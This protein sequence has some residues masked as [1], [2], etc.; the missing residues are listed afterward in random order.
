MKIWNNILSLFLV[1]LWLAACTSDDA[2]EVAPSAEDT[3]EVM[4]VIDA[5]APETRATV[6]YDKEI[7]TIRIY[8]YLH[9]TA[10][11]AVSPIGYYYQEVE[12][13]GPY[14]CTMDLP[15]V[16]T[17]VVDFLVTLNDG[18]MSGKDTSV[19]LNENTTRNEV[20]NYMFTANTFKTDADGYFACP[21]SN[22]LEEGKTENNVDENNRSFTIRKTTAPQLIDIVCTR[23]MA[24]LRLQFAKIGEDEAVINSATLRYGARYTWLMREM[25]ITDDAK[26]TYD[27]PRNLEDKFLTSNVVINKVVQ[28][29]G[30]KDEQDYQNIVETYM[31]ENLYGA[32]DAD[33]EPTV[34]NSDRIYRLDISYTTN[35]TQHTKKVYLPPVKRN[36]TINVRGT[37]VSNS[38]QIQLTAEPWTVDANEID[39][40]TDWNSEL[41]KGTSYKEIPDDPDTADKD[42]RAVAVATSSDGKARGATFQFRVSSPEGGTWTAHLSSTV[43]F[44]LEGTTSGVGAENPDWA[45]FTIVPIGNYNPEITQEVKLFI[46][47]ASPFGGTMEDEGMQII[48]PKDDENGTYPFP[49]NETEILIRQVS[50]NAYDDLPVSDN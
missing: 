6:N 27:D 31:L 8:A 23:A 1:C 18:S 49:G 12:G 15:L 41:Q 5:N 38:L 45:T 47:L 20:E 17:T 2:A 37:L 26:E 35:G 48:N 34:A 13:N 9:D 28:A 19:A 11:K 33:N 25:T 46:T 4:L 39:F 43:D 30:S 3:T 16:E 14:Y 7:R 22:L 42:E 40:S 32:D 50:E 10:G 24:R 44:R 29:V 21:M 36:Q